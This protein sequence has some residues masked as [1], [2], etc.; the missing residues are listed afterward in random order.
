[1]FG[2]K[3]DYLLLRPL[4]HS[5]CRATEEELD[6]SGD[7]S[8]LGDQLE[9]KLPRILERFEGHFPISP[10]L[11]YL[12]MGCGSGELT[13]GLAKLGVRDIV[14]VDFLPR[15]IESAR[16]NAAAAGIERGVRFICAD[17]HTWP[18]EEKFDV[19]ISF[20]ALE[21]IS[22]PKAFMATMA[23]FLAPGGI[24][25]L[26]FGPLFHSPFGDHMSEFF[27]L[28]V[29]WRGALFNEAAMMRVRRECYRPT[30]PASRYT[31]VAGGLNLMRYSDFLRF[32]PE[33][34][35]Q[36]RFLRTNTFLKNRVLSRISSVL[37]A[38]PGIQDYVI[39]NVYAVLTRPTAANDLDVRSTKV[40]ETE[41]LAA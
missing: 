34:G 4:A 14:G 15:F 11:R 12:D 7:S 5:R 40:A 33:T 36:Y 21:H 3:L 30:D 28:Q 1:M 37:S 18:T 6:R 26:S 23:R 8:L 38:T 10:T 16:R 27:R 24:A 25:V 9:T 19:I 35:W 20:D 2:E 17:L 39:H 13:L 32:T 31:E 41:R 29:P 22:N